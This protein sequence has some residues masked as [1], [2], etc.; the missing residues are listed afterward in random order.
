[1]RRGVRRTVAFVAVLV[2]LVIGPAARG[3]DSFGGELEFLFHAGLNGDEI[4]EAVVGVQARGADTIAEFT[5]PGDVFVLVRDESATPRALS[6]LCVPSASHPQSPS[7]TY[8]DLL[9]AGR[10]VKRRLSLTATA[11]ATHRPPYGVGR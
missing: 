3:D 1:M 6:F 7:V 9:Q 4:D 8:R 10:R 11:C 5:D 2:A